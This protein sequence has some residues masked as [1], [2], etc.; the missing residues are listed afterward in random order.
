MEATRV[1]RARW[2]P[3]TYLKRPVPFAQNPSLFTAQVYT[4]AEMLRRAAPKVRQIRNLFIID[5]DKCCAERFRVLFQ[6]DEERNGERLPEDEEDRAVLEDISTQVFGLHEDRLYCKSVS[7]ILEV[8]ASTLSNLTPAIAHTVETLLLPATLPVLSD[9]V[10][11]SLDEFYGLPISKKNRSSILSPRRLHLAELS[12]S[13]W[14]EFLGCI[15]TFAPGLTDIRVTGM[16]SN[17]HLDLIPK[18][19]KK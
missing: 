18:S 4:F 8:N 6:K 17:L 12:E 13:C 16:S 14:D 11:L 9:L 3:D 10:L 19:V 7:S 15:P 2:C 1:V 5:L